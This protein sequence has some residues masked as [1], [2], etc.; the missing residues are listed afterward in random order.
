MLGRL[1]TLRR[2]R[3]EKVQETAKAK[4]DD[5]GSAVTAEVALA[6]EDAEDSGSDVDFDWRAKGFA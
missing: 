1:E 2:K 3:N 6:E 4:T 5:G